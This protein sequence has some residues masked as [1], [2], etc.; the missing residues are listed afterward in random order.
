METRVRPRRRW[1]RSPGSPICTLIALFDGKKIPRTR[2]ICFL[3]REP[4][5]RRFVV[6]TRIVLNFTLSSRIRRGIMSSR[7]FAS[8]NFRMACKIVLQIIHNF[9]SLLHIPFHWWVPLPPPFENYVHSEREFARLYRREIYSI[10][11]NRTARTFYDQER[12][13]DS[14]DRCN[15]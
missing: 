2:E 14:A 8:L 9:T 6:G 7:S 4:I 5:A 3:R 13:I 12:K 10:V 15:V 11:F 1:T